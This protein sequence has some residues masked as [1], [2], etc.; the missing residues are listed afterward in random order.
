MNGPDLWSA[1]FQ[2]RQAAAGFGVG[3]R[4]QAMPAFWGEPVEVERTAPGALVPDAL[5]ESCTPQAFR[6]LAGGETA[7]ASRKSF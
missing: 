1:P 7:R 5:P 4:E 2:P 6:A 3:A